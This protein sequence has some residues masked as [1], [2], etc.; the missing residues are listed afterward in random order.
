[1][2]VAIPIIP[3]AERTPLV[4]SLLAIIDTLQQHI[5]QLEEN[6][7]QVRDEVAILKGEKPRPKIEPSQL[8]KPPPKPTSTEAKKRPGSEKR[9][10]N[11]TLK[12]TEEWLVLVQDA[13]DGSTHLHY[14]K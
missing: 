1:M 11:A 10:K 6:V 7:Q 5:Q 8:E 4:E 12:I 3:D 2:K 14:E 13:P 9:A